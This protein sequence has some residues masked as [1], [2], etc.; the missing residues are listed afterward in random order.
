MRLFI[1]LG[2]ISL[3]IWVFLSDIY[4]QTNN[5][6]CVGKIR[7]AVTVDVLDCQVYKIA[8][9]PATREDMNLDFISDM[10]PQERAKFVASYSGM[11]L[12]VFVAK[13]TAKKTGALATNKNVL[14]G[15][16]IWVYYP[17]RQ[18]SC[19][20]VSG[21]RLVGELVEHCC[22]G[23]AE[24]PCLTRT[25]YVLTQ[26]KAVGKTPVNKKT[27]TKTKKSKEYTQAM[28]F[29]KQ[30]QY[31]KAL[32]ILHKLY[33]E[34]KLDVEGIYYLAVCYSQ[35]E[36]PVSA[37]KVLEKIVE[38]KDNE[39]L[40]GEYK[41]LGKEA[42]F[43][44]ARCYARNQEAGRSTI[45]LG[46]YLQDPVLYKKYIERSLSHPDFGWIKVTKDYQNY[47][48]KAVQALQRKQ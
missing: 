12:K 33:E 35:T 8:P 44:L 3:L 39:T 34:S 13:S 45:I 22:L 37:I 20:M 43:L 42:E 25:D 16:T 26:T 36:R 11:L 19:N 41:E 38:K 31:D 5:G 15:D 6:Q 1:N 4:A 48:K 32:P 7:G 29:I 17:V 21:Q 28:G 47:R 18:P 10:D 30:K 23:N 27:V 14:N 24:P 9:G 46:G 40:W 2:F